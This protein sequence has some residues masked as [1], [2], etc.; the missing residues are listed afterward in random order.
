M[1]GQFGHEQQH[2]WLCPGLIR[3]PDTD[4]DPLGSA[5]GK[6][7][8]PKLSTSAAEPLQPLGVVWKPLGVAGW[9][10]F[11]FPSPSSPPGFPSK[12]IS[13]FSLD[14]PSC[15][16]LLVPHQSPGNIPKEKFALI[17]LW[18]PAPLGGSLRH[19]FSLP[20]I[21]GWK[22]CYWA[23]CFSGG[24]F[25]KLERGARVLWTSVPSSVI[26]HCFSKYDT[27]ES[28]WQGLGVEPETLHF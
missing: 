16:A 28:C 3:S 17:H 2:L 26:Q 1:R 27:Q 9:T 8:L 10:Q 11:L 21:V 15:S 5:L 25:R 23:K 6:G 22:A 19:T 14:A 20:L 7:N 24:S 18:K 13:L 12:A 4:S